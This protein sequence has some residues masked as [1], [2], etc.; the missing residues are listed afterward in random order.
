[1]TT[2]N[3]RVGKGTKPE[4]PLGAFKSLGKDIL[5]GFDAAIDEAM[6]K[7]LAVR[8]AERKFGAP[9]TAGIEVRQEGHIFRRENPE[10]R[11]RADALKANRDRKTLSAEH[12]KDLGAYA[13]AGETY[14]LDIAEYL[15]DKTDTLPGHLQPLGQTLTKASVQIVST[16]YIESLKHN[17]EMGFL[18]I[19][20]AT[21]PGQR[22]S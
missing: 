2:T 17:A 21:Q 13:V 7:S 5:D 6:N 8:E 19:T 20:A 4:D 12:I 14:V 16:A 22:R 10:D 18:E 9:G 15:S 3:G 1:M 11:K